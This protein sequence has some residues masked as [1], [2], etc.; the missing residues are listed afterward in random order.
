M[1]M[2]SV[3]KQLLLCKIFSTKVIMFFI[4]EELFLYPIALL[5][6]KF[7]LHVC[8]SV[9]NHCL[10]GAYALMHVTLQFN[11]VYYL[12]LCFRECYKS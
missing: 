10:E 6:V 8:L 1:F 4:S 11:T 7:E 9:H 5:C 3:L 2:I 12:R